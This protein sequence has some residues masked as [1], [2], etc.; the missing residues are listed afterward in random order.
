MDKTDMSPAKKE[1]CR[2]QAALTQSLGQISYRPF[3]WSQTPQRKYHQI[4]QTHARAPSGCY[5][6]PKTCS[7]VP[8]LGLLDILILIFRI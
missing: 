1:Q 7:L 3:G 8:H 4:P 2:L 6:R 5:Q